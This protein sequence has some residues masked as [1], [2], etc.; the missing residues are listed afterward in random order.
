MAGV[1]HHFEGDQ[2]YAPFG[3]KV[4]QLSIPVPLF[5]AVRVG[6]DIELWRQ[7]GERAC[8]RH[9]MLGGG[10][11]AFRRRFDGESVE[12][13]KLIAKPRRLQ[14]ETR[15]AEGVGGDN[16]SARPNVV[17]VYFAQERLVSIGRDSAPGVLVH[18]DTA[19]L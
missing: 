11:P 4:S 9:R 6:S 10:I 17:L 14:H 15:R 12:L 3:K 1:L 2:V 13:S 16:F 5:R 19:A 8:D 7:A 18:G